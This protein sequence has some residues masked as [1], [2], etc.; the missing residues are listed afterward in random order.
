M[1]WKWPLGELDGVLRSPCASNHT[2]EVAGISFVQ[3][4][5]RRGFD[6]ARAAD[7]H[8]DVGSRLAEA[9]QSGAKPSGDRGQ[10]EHAAADDQRL[11]TRRFDV[12]E[13][14]VRKHG[15]SHGQRAVVNGGVDAISLPFRIKEVFDDHLRNVTMPA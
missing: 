15:A 1:P 11:V 6:A 2:R 12:R 13:R 14:G 5:D 7:G 9:R 4:R 10:P 3:V 8:H